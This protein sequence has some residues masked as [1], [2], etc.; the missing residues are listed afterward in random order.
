LGL[1][2]LQAFL[3]RHARICLDTSVFIYQA[4]QHVRYAELAYAVFEWIQ[5]P[6]NHAVTS[7]VTMTEL[8]VQAY[9][10]GNKH[11]SDTVYGIFLQYPNLLWIPADLDVADLAARVRARHRMRTPD[12]LQA[13]TALFGGATAIVTNDPVFTKLE[14]IEVAVLETFL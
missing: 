7:T 6:G 12:A 4:D 11:R 2:A 13:A 3:S 10:D 9:R 14:E 1:E 5:R 8:M